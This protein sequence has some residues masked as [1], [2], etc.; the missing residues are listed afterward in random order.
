MSIHA[1]PHRGYGLALASVLALHADPFLAP[2]PGA[3][4]EKALQV[5]PLVD[6]LSQRAGMGLFHRVVTARGAEIDPGR[7]G[8]H[9]IKPIGITDT[10]LPSAPEV[11]VVIEFKQSAFDMFRLMG[12]FILE[13][14]N[15]K[16]VGTLLHTD[17]AQFENE[18]TGGYLIMKR[19][20][21]GFPAGRYRVEIH[22]GEQ[23]NDISLLTL[24]RFK[25]VEATKPVPAPAP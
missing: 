8:L 1:L 7:A 5:V 6:P 2:A 3:G 9:M 17:K 16:P 13:D 4:P 12:R 22:Y 10:F 19:P 23:V 24:A 21:G 25:V 15:G 14:P 11:Y 20:P 18:D